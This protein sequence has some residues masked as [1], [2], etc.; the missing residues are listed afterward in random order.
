MFIDH[1][2]KRTDY[3]PLDQVIC[4][5]SYVKVRSLISNSREMVRCHWF[6]RLKFSELVTNSIN[7]FWS[8]NTQRQ[9]FLI[10]ELNHQ[11][12]SIN[13][14]LI[15]RIEV[16]CFD[17]FFVDFIFIRSF[18]NIQFVTS[19]VCWFSINQIPIMIIENRNGI[20]GFSLCYVVEFLFWGV[21]FEIATKCLILEI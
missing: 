11:R 17:K 1:K 3:M 2:S 18:D 12:V 14:I 15:V 16:I 7:I 21:R 20:C 9:Q 13:Q 8:F 4:N 6:L 19:I 5:K 10:C